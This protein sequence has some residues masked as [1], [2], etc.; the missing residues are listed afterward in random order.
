M[1]EAYHE[2]CSCI[3]AGLAWS[4][5]C[6]DFDFDFDQHAICMVEMPSG[7]THV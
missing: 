1:K 2:E 6:T 7:H 3:R 5:A 4:M